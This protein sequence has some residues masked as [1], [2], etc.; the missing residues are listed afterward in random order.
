MFTRKQDGQQGGENANAEENEV[1]QPRTSTPRPTEDL[2]AKKP[3]VD[4]PRTPT[5]YPTSEPRQSQPERRDDDSKLLVGDGIKLKGEI[6]NCA[7]LVVEGTVDAK[8]EATRFQIS[9]SGVY[10][11]ECN[12]QDADIAGQFD[13]VLNCRGKLIVRG[14]G[15]VKGTL[16]YGDVEIEAGGRISGEIQVFGEDEPAAKPVAV[17]DLKAA[18]E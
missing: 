5:S 7:E 12:V 16:R 13:G 17:Q 11:G 4:I 15:K 18:G 2:I 8:V 9:Q 1:R 3:R 10:S 14:S 6:T